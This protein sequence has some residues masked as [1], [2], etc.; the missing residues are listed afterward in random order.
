[1]KIKSFLLLGAL[2]FGS[3]VSRA[4]EGMWMPF[5]LKNNFK[6]MK[7]MGLKLTPQQIYDINN[8]SLKDA[9]V[10][11]GGG[12]TGEVISNKGLILTNHHCG[13]GAIAELSTPEHNYLRDGFWARTFEEELKPKELTVRF[14]VQ[15]GDVTKRILSKVNDQMTTAQRTAA[16]NE[17]MKAI[18]KEYN[19]NGAYAVQVRSFYEGNEYYFFVYEDF[20]DVRL[21]GT[22]TE[23][24][25]KFGGD[26]DN[27]EW[28]RHTGDFSLFRVYAD[29]NNKPAPY[30]KDNV[31]FTPKHHLPINIQGYKPGEF[32]M[33][34]GYPGRTNRWMPAQGV[35]QNVKY[36]YPAWVEAS[37]MAMDVIKKHT[38]KDEKTRLDYASKYSSIANYWKNRQGMIDDLTKHKTVE[39]KTNQEAIFNKWA[40][41]KKN[42]SR[43]GNVI[44]DINAYYAAT[45]EKARHDNYL[46]MV[47]RGSSFA[48]IAFRLGRSFEQYAKANNR[49]EQRADMKASIHEF[50]E[51]LNMNLERDMLKAMLS[52]YVSKSVGYPIVKQLAE[53]QESNGNNFDGFVNDLFENSIFGSEARAMSFLDNASLDALEKDPMMVFSKNLVQHLQGSASA[54][55]LAKQE[56]YNHA[57]RLMVE[58]MRKANKKGRFYPDAN[59]TMRLTYGK[60]RALPADARNKA[61]ENYYTILEDMVRKH[62]EG[63]PEFHLSP[64]VREIYNSKDYGPYVDK[65]GYMFVNFLTDHDI[66]GGNSGSPVV[67]GKGE[68]I[69]LAFD[70]NI[71]AMAG[72]VIFDANLQRTI[73]VDIRFVLLIMDKYA[74]AQNLIDELTLVK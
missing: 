21:V 74:G 10:H 41:S 63:D 45:N 56:K 25:G 71:E 70:G 52:L 15:M 60:V 17:E 49:D 11:F 20:T 40:N 29:K 34:M 67:N 62:K 53:V 28:P 44:A 4:D 61:P 54:D 38:D 51:S 50:Y 37:K 5:M 8:A 3:F 42:K 32:S 64:K 59:S 55:I 30:S 73:N 65:N 48:T 66:T 39:K 46:S 14:L 7:K 57:F 31:P 68:L 1:M 72:D 16:I 13:Y 22:P 43:Y 36:A 47:T 23:S 27:W 33:I 24:V 6:D 35:E 26:T 18:Q 2:G 12:C 58:G 9:I 19:N 69:G